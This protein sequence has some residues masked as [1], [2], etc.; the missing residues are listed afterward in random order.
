[1]QNHRPLWS[2]KDK[3]ITSNIAYKSFSSPNKNYI[4]G[5]YIY[6]IGVS[7]ELGLVLLEW[8]GVKPCAFHR[9]WFLQ[10]CVEVERRL[11]FLLFFLLSFS[12][13]PTSFAC[14]LKGAEELLTEW[15]TT[16][17][18]KL[19]IYELPWLQMM[20]ICLKCVVFWSLEEKRWFNVWEIQGWVTTI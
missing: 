11:W 14:N 4:Y 15:E 13:H 2:W 17:L 6:I 20:K 1:M 8:L 5:T 3:E 9:L 12:G 7:Y 18:G 16:Q 19:K 10:W